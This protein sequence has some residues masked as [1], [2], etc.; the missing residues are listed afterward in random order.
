MA[1]RIP[2]EPPTAQ[3]RMVASYFTLCQ[4]IG[5]EIE[6]AGRRIA[7][8]GIHAPVFCGYIIDELRTLRSFCDR[9]EAALVNVHQIWNE[10]AETRSNQ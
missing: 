10:A 2:A 4:T 7:K 6:D 1:K 9:A 3:S 5:G 8:D